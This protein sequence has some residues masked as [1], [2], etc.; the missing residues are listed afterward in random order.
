MHTPALPTLRG[1]PDF[2]PVFIVGLPRTGTTLVAST[3]QKYTDVRDRGELNWIAALYA[4]LQ[5]QGQLHNPA[6]LASIAAMI[7]AQMRR[8]DSPARF[9]VDKNPLNFRYLDFIT[10]L[11]PN[12]KIIHCQ[13]G[14]RDT[15]LSLWMQHFAHED[16]GFSYAFSRIA[17][18]EKGYRTLMAHW[19]SRL[20]MDILDV[21]YEAFVA[22][23]HAE[24]QRLAEFLGVG[25]ADNRQDT[26]ANSAVVT[27]ASVWQVRQPIHT[28]SVERWRHYSAFLP[29]LI[30]RFPE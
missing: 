12:A 24:K 10:A 15:A 8:D 18:L 20:A 30:E 3:L 23:P 29:E 4:H 22:N 6:A 21:D 11:F 9:Y 7:C 13:R 14:S 2:V 1:D 16:L 26:Q 17:E 25:R 5:E 28:Q 27:T 19:R